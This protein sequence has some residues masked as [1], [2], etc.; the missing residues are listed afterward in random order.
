[1]IEGATSSA[2]EPV[3]SGQYSLRATNANGCSVTSEL[4]EVVLAGIEDGYQEISA[5]IYPVPA[6]DVLELEFEETLQKGTTIKLL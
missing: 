5:K 1:E 4:V 6:T 2:F 3:L